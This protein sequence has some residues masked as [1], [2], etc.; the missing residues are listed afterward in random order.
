MIRARANSNRGDAVFVIQPNRNLSWKRTKLVFFCLAFCIC[1]VAAY[2]VYKG[3]WLV[4][5]FTGL[6]LIVLG[7]GLY[8]QCC[9][10]YRK[11]VVSVGERAVS[12]NDGRREFMF[13]KAWL[14][15]IH[16]QDS[17]GWYP[18]RLVIGSHGR[19]IEIGDFLVES[20]RN[21]L[22]EDLRCAI[23]GA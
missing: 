1:S 3:A 6:E 10:A 19:F 9:H 22:A 21:R 5:P 2:F 20:E 11:E 7:L 23:Q 13:S 14:S 8:L 16:S 15:I 12:V 17:T 4:L 18:S